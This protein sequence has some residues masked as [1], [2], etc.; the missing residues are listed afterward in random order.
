MT[1]HKSPTPKPIAVLISDVHY[2]LQTL[3]LAD[4]AMRMALEKADQLRV[5]LIV[6]GDLHDTKAAMRAECVNAMLRTFSAVVYW[7][8]IILVGN[9]DKINEKSTEHSLKFLENDHTDVRGDPFEWADGIHLVPYQHDLVFLKTYLRDICPG[10]VVIMHQ[11]LQGSDSGDYFQ[12]PTA[13]SHEDVAH[14]RVISGHY[15]RRQDIDTGKG[16]TFSYIG[17]PYT[18]GFGE[19]NH[20]EKGF[21]ILHS[22]G[23]LEFVPTNLRKH[24]IITVGYNNEDGPRGIFWTVPIASQPEDLVWVKV[25]GT[26]EQL[27]KV[28]K[29]FLKAEMPWL[30]EFKLEL[31]YE[32]QEVMTEAPPSNMTK[33]S[34]L[35]RMIDTLSATTDA[36]KTRL[37]SLWKDLVK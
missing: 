23:S 31:I 7:R 14:L 13:L 3:E 35:D 33:E 18:L 22:D 24:R 29:E 36:Q 11:G 30:N 37:K 4:K 25:T 15:H 20:P 5:P 16:N 27:K 2:N 34:I 8:P 9:H 1:S 19:A 17:N 10:S 21:Q 32:D 28:N 26:R 12:D 6:A